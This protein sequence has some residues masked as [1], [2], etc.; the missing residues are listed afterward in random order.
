[1]QLEDG[2]ARR[3]RNKRELVDARPKCCKMLLEDEGD[4]TPP[5]G[6]KYPTQPCALAKTLP[7]TT[8]R[9]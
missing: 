6:C 5:R 1:M 9:A 8:V 2:E 4:E 7:E 3:R